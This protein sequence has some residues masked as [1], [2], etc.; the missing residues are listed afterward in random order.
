MC[1]LRAPPPHLSGLVEERE[2]ATVVPHLSLQ[3]SR[4][5]ESLSCQWLHNINSIALSCFSAAR[6]KVND[7]PGA[8][9]EHS[10]VAESNS[11]FIVQAPAHR[12]AR[13]H[14]ALSSL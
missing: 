6:T 2:A 11:A 13:H 10:L 14:E 12:A 5:R 1:L 9:A 8:P 3:H 4:L 7:D